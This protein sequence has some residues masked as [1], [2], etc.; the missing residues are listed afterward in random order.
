M[1]Y[2]L[3]PLLIILSLQSCKS[4]KLRRENKEKTAKIIIGS[5]TPE[6]NNAIE[7]SSNKP[8]STRKS[9]ISYAEQF[10]GTPYKWGGTTKRGMDCSGLVFESF[11]S[12]NIFLKLN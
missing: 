11:Q 7:V 1:K 2:L 6:F 8:R 3:I 10:L 4:S 12:E 9:V 5:K